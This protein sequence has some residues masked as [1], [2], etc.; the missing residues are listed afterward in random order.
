[1]SACGEAEKS[2]SSTDNLLRRCVGVMPRSDK[3]NGLCMLRRQGR[4]GRQRVHDA[5]ADCGVGATVEEET[6]P[7]VEV[8]VVT[9]MC[10]HVA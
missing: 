8:L 1:M 7:H 9:R 10:L 3:D 4:S 6:S 5:L 2:Q